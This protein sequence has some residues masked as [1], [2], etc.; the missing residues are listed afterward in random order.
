MRLPMSRMAERK[1]NASAQINIPGCDPLGGWMNAA[2][3]V[4]SGIL[5]VTSVS[6]TCCAAAS[7]EPAA[8]ARPAATDNARK[9]RR[10]RSAPS[11]CSFSESCLS[12][13]VASS[14]ERLVDLRAAFQRLPST[15]LEPYL[16]K[17]PER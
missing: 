15:H 12:S 4:P 9:S 17:Q 1:P 7:V 13:I 10:E 3:H 2:S 5:I 8:A 16:R 14:L 11:L 6:T